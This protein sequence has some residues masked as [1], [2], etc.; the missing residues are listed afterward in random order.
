LAG[1]VAFVTL[2]WCDWSASRWTTLQ[3]TPVSATWGGALMVLVLLLGILGRVEHLN[4]ENPVP[5]RWSDAFFSGN[6]QI[7]ALGLNR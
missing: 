6:N 5:L 3:V 1:T 4:F 2:A 7:A